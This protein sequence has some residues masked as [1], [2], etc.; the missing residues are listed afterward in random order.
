MFAQKAD[1][2]WV[3]LA[4]ISFETVEDEATGFPVQLPKFSDAIMEMNGQ[5]IT[6]KGYLLPEQGYKSHREFILSAFPYALCYFC[7]KAGPETV[8][9]VSSLDAIAFTNE[10][11]TLKGTLMLNNL[12]P[13]RLIYVLTNAKLVK[14]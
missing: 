5:E 8:M 2:T 10:P 6:I 13:F 14:K 3:E 9:E 11:I 7:G 12:D 1:N 4:D